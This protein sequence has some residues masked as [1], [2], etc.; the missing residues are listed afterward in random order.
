MGSGFI[1]SVLTLSSGVVI[2][3]AIN[4][5]AMPLVGRLYDPGEIGDFQTIT[6]NSTIIGAIVC[7]GM[8]T[9]LIIPKTD[10]ESRRLCKLTTAS[11]LV[12][13]TAACLGLYFL[14]GIFRLVETE[15]TS[16]LAAIII[17]WL[18]TV[19]NT[20]NNI[21][22]AYVNRLRM[23]RVMFWNPIIGAAVNMGCSILFG[24]LGWGA[25]GY[26]SANILAFVCNIIHLVLR[27]N[28]FVND[29]TSLGDYRR[30]LKDYRAFPVYQMPAN[31]VANVGNQMP[32]WTI[33]SIFG[34]SALGMYS[35]ALK[36]LGLPTT[37]LATPIN[38]V[39]FQEASKRYNDGEDIGEF[40]FRI[41]E[42][43][44]KL[45]ILP[46]AVLVIL[47]KQIFSIFLGA[48]WATAGVY[49]TILGVYQLMLFCNSCL[50]GDFVIIKRNKWNL[51]SAVLTIA[52]QLSVFLVFKYIVHA[53]IY[54]FL[55]ALSTAMICK[56]VFVQSWFF[57]FLKFDMRKY[58]L[59]IAK[60]IA[61]P[62]VL[63]FLVYLFL[64]P[65]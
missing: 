36:I 34:A 25:S 9:A 11:T 3:Q 23:Y 37:L 30:L 12:L 65:R 60:F 16:Y 45:A 39:F 46:I 54:T 64:I 33:K 7:L 2:G 55:M 4:F 5:V 40:S 32:V 63:T 47:G 13:S 14:R 35:M 24:Y 15:T 20:I 8:M 29:G 38:R 43:N 57:R 62:L 27:A 1:K 22:Y 58:L 61:A 6:A 28:P 10:V 18:F 51:F 50:A 19:F 48:Q 52:V 42:A 26:T 59:F 53:D 21:C 56:I 49:A 44:I 17:L 41:L 31:V